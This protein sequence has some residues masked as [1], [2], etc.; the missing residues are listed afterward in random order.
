MA[1]DTSGQVTIRGEGSAT[2]TSLQQGLLKV[3]INLTGTGTIAT[4]DSF[5][6]SGTTDNGT[7][8]YTI[9]I[10]SDMS[11]AN[12][13]HGGTPHYDDS[14]VSIYTLGLPDNTAFSSTRT[15]GLIRYESAYVASDSNR[16]NFDTDEAT[17]HIAGDL[18]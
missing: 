17:I 6:V 7:G 5:N 4:K 8:D 15:T 12:Y 11:S 1:I 16:T 18:A 2:T 9:S 13:C 14:T 3:W 10:N